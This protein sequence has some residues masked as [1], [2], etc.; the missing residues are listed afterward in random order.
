LAARSVATQFPNGAWGYDDG[1]SDGLIETSYQLL[2]LSHGRHPIFMN[3]LRFERGVG[4]KLAGGPVP[5]YWSNRPRDVAN[6]TRYASREL[7]RSFNW[8]VVDL[9]REWHDWL[10]CPVLYIASHQPPL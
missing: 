4:E 1:R 6:L 10:D 7:E 2:F 3:K 8:Q 5:G 9:G